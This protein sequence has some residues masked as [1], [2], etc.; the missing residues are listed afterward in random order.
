[1]V[2]FSVHLTDIKTIKSILPLSMFTISLL[3]D[4]FPQFRTTLTIY[5]LAM[6]PNI[7]RRNL[8]PA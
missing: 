1:M 6:V 5:H 8:G 4:Q 3:E 2:F 7:E